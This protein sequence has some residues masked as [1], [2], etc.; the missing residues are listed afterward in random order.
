MQNKIVPT[1]SEEGKVLV[2]W[3]RIHNITFSH[4]P[5]ETGHSDEAKRRAI[6]MKQ[7]GTSKGFPDYVIALPGIGMVYIE[8]KRLRGSTTS[9]EQ[10]AWIEAIKE[11]PGAEACIARGADEAIAFVKLLISGEPQ[12]TQDLF[13][14]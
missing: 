11:C 12:P 4:I 9:P 10:K 14:F 7:Q 5:N 6:R 13:P 3:L 1:E 8:L 2:Q